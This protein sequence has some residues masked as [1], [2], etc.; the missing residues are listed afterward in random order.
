MFH[1]S[2]HGMRKWRGKL[3]KLLTLTSF[4]LCLGCTGVS[5]VDGTG[6]GLSQQDCASFQELLL[7]PEFQTVGDRGSV[8]HYRQHAGERSF[9]TLSEE[10]MLTFARIGGEPWAVLSQKIQSPLLSGREVIYSVDLKG[11]VSAKVTHGFGAKSGLYLRR[12]FRKDVSQAEHEP[13]LGQWDWQRVSIGATLA[14]SHDSVE[15]GFLY[16]GGAGALTAKNPTL[17]LVG[18]MY[19]D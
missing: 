14:D 1:L 11:D 2:E 5:S 16:Q 7:D 13:N 10:G 8:W 6:S 19:E 4:A 12:G 9:S 3:V 17:Q 18:C 15:V